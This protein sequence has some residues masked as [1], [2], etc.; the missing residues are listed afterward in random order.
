MPGTDVVLC[1]QQDS[2]TLL[3]PSTAAGGVAEDAMVSE[4]CRSEGAVVCW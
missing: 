2:V 4:T 1:L 3:S